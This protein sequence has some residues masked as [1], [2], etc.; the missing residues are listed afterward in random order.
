MTIYNC[1]REDSYLY[2]YFGQNTDIKL[3][4]GNNKNVQT[5]KE[6]D[7][8]HGTDK[9]KIKIISRFVG[10]NFI[11]KIEQIFGDNYEVTGN[12][13]LYL[14]DTVK[15]KKVYVSV[16]DFLK[17]RKNRYMGI[18][19]RTE[20]LRQIKIYLD[21]IDYYYGFL[22]DKNQVFTLSDGTVV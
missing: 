15:R 2:K 9:T 14:M 22:L 19:E 18:N 21:R 20:S 4:N 10:V 7:V 5:I 13:L 3:W 17:S 12:H 1:N 16:E 11:Y 8:L 6:G